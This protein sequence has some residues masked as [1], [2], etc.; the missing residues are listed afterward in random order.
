MRQQ[1]VPQL[2]WRASEED[3]TEAVSR[4]TGN[5]QLLTWMYE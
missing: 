5:N 3:E 1:E 4:N 2:C